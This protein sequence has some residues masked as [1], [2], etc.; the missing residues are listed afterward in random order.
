MNGI[1]MP[2]KS[3]NGNLIFKDITIPSTAWQS[4]DTY[5]NFAYVAQV[6]LSGCK[7]NMFPLVSYD[8][9]HLDFE[10]VVETA[11]GYLNI[12]AKS[13]PSEDIVIT[14]LA[15]IAA[16]PDLVYGPTINSCYEITA[17]E[18]EA[19]SQEDQ[20]ALY[21][22]GYRLIKTTNNDTVVLL[23]LS[24]D[25]SLQWLGC[26]QPRG[27]L[28]DNGNFINPVNQ[29]GVTSALS[30][31]SYYFIDRWMTYQAN[32]NNVTYSL[33]DNGISLTPVEQ[34]N[35][36]GMQQRI[37]T[38][39]STGEDYTIIFSVDGDN[40]VLPITGGT[41]KIGEETNNIYLS[42]VTDYGGYNT[43]RVV[44]TTNRSFVVNNA[45]VIKG[46][47]TPK[48]LPPWEKPDVV[49]ELQKCLR[50]AWVIKCNSGEMMAISGMS[51]ADG[52]AV[53]FNVVPPVPMRPGGAPT[54]VI[55]SSV[56]VYNQYKVP[57]AWDVISYDPNDNGISMFTLRATFSSAA[58][59]MASAP[60]YISIKTQTIGFY[61]D[62]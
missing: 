6:D 17:Q 1:I 45:R 21:E 31:S 10:N 4:S 13:Q 28:L 15:L 42:Y 34:G 61:R 53:Y 27:N 32:V 16:T 37:E 48:T 59:P 3:L 18:L 58:Y 57:D 29:R 54:V 38:P 43:V 40:I 8:V 60:A 24:S 52:T 44:F 35:Y 49:S 47:Y 62:L 12:Y 55:P 41:G 19:M 33:V 25:G 22:K 39:L 36:A 2:N 5:N 51:N 20:V 14:N 23:A 26:N 7:E 11:N 50:Y 46:N 56:T 9:E 30:N